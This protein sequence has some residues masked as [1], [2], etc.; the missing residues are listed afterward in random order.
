MLVASSST[1]ILWSHYA[2]RSCRYGHWQP[3]NST[4]PSKEGSNRWSRTEASSVVYTVNST[5]LNY[6]EEPRRLGWQ[7]KTPEYHEITC[8]KA[9]RQQ[10]TWPWLHMYL[11]HIVHILLVCSS[12][13]LTTHLSCKLW[14]RWALYCATLVRMYLSIIFQ[15]HSATAVL[16]SKRK[17]EVP[18]HPGIPPRS[19][20]DLQLTVP[21]ERMSVC[22]P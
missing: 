21:V 4:S 8:A 22:I 9:L 6:M 17:R 2:L 3:I 20:N 7:G 19:A 15:Q 11:V 12:L 1:S 5:R 10:H 13:W 14:S 18:W 16:H